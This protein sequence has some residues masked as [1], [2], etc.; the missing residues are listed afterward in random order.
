MI[1]LFIKEQEEELF[2]LRF[3]ETPESAEVS[4]E[5]APEDLT[6]IRNAL[7]EVR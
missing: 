4:V 7:N 2:T 6:I 1:Q 3:C 5:L